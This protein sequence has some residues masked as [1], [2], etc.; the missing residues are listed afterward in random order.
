MAKL[1]FS[2]SDHPDI[3]FDDVFLLPD[4]DVE[5][6]VL[7]KADDQE[8]A[9]IEELKQKSSMPNCPE[10][11]PQCHKAYRSALL[12]LA[13]KY[14]VG[15][16]LSRDN[17]DLKPN[18]NLSNTP[19]V[20]SNMNNVTGKRMAEAIARVGGIA[21]IPQ[22]KSDKE[23]TGIIDYLRNCHPVYE[24]PI[25]L[26]EDAKIHEFRA[27]LSKRSHGV[28][29]VTDEN[30]VFLGVLSKGD[31]PDGINSDLPVAPFVRKDNLVTAQSGI[32][33]L[34]AIQ[35]MES[36]HVSYLPIV[37]GGD[38][39]IGVLPLMDAAMRL[40]YAPNVDPRNGGLRALYTIGAL[41]KNPIDRLKFLLDNG[42]YDILFDTANFDQGIIPYRNLEKA[43][44]AAEN[45]GV[46]INLMAGNVVTREATRNILAAGGQYVKVGVGPG[47]MCTTR[48]QT[49]VGRPQVS[50]VME[51]AEEA[52]KHGGYVVADGGVQHPRDVAIAM[53]VGADYV[54]VGSL[55][56]GT[57]E[58]PSDLNGNEK[59]GYFKVNYG[60]A[61][62]RAS[63][64]RTL[65]KEKRNPMDIFRSIVGQRSEGISESKV[66]LKPGRESV[67][68][69]QH[70]LLDGTA[71]SAAYANARSLKEFPARAVM[72][73][74]TRSGFAEGTAK[75]KF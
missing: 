75:E 73:I 50:A 20:I 48:M 51:C 74:Q 47:A 37:N 32:E 11:V 31:I 6:E 61:S 21:A 43:R 56:T 18:G 8:K 46:D 58:S 29:I 62:T 23:L 69:L 4:N 3:T 44:S 52:H 1:L 17:V 71:S 19:I 22:D 42:V 30:G 60:M 24:T 2:P 16:S 38:Q 66:Y 35:L 68:K 41:N 14:N 10:D 27:L 5:L 55:F 70:D 26:S 15:G 57:Y 53:A 25:K 9:L 12:D 54:M 72:G 64:L 63:V 28:A 59:D 36:H 34:E 33:P 13:E 39:I 7:A 40:R 45:K 49:A 65:G 67:A